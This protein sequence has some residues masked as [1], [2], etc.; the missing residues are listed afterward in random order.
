MVIADVLKRWEL[1]KPR[2]ALLCTGTDEH[3]LKVQQAADFQDVPPKTLCDT[4]SEIFKDLA[5]K[6][7]ISNDHFIRTTDPEHREAV[8]YFWRRLQENGHI[9]E[10]KHAGWYCVSDE[11]YYPENMITK[12]VHPHTGKTFMASIET[13][14][15]VEWTEEKNYHFRLTAFKEKLLEFFRENPNWVTP[16]SRMREVV[17]WVEN[18]LEDL[19]VSRPAS[20]L[21]WGIPVPDDPSQTIYVW[22][23]ALVNYITYAG[24]PRWTPGK[25]NRGG[26]PADV[27]VIGKD[28]MRFHCIYWPALLMAL[29]LPLPKRILTH[30]HWLMDAKKMSKS[31]GN[32]VNPFFAIDRWG[33]DTMRYYLMY[34]GAMAN[35][36]S[37]SNEGVVESY[38][39]GLQSTTGNFL[40]RITKPNKWDVSEAV[41]EIYRNMLELDIK[42]PRAQAFARLTDAHQE[43]V[44]SLAESVGQDFDN[45][46]PKAALRKIMH[47]LGESNKYMTEAAPWNLSNNGERDYTRLVH[48]IYLCAESMRVAAILLQPFIPE[49][50]AEILDRL[51]VDSKKRTLEYA[52]RGRDGEY[53]T[54]KCKTNQSMTQQKTSENEIQRAHCDFDTKG[55]ARSAIR[56]ATASDRLSLEEEYEN[57]ISWRTSADKL[58]FIVCK[59]LSDGGHKVSAGVADAN[60]HMVGDINLFLTPWEDDEEQDDEARGSRQRLCV[61]EVDIM[62]AAPTDRGRGMGKAAVSTFLWFIKK[63]MGAILAEY[64]SSLEDGGVLEIKELLVRINASNEGSKALFK[65]LGFEQRGEVNYF[66]EIEL[67]LKDFQGERGVSEVQEYRE[68]P[69]DRSGLAA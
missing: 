14:N 51:G 16:P 23:D 48:C 2:R 31:V 39:K 36:S 25:E 32:V 66:G 7:N 50:A 63:N 42:S 33:V 4:N 15:A 26:W 58:T 1:L 8:E 18:N 37:Y 69:F 62:I 30:G 56:E 41:R 43:L 68:L 54:P 35:D 11:T 49:K 47:F 64:A 19:S 52:K 67:V 22:I 27:H 12:Q 61:G 20:R 6:A 3:G 13:G 60:E 46:A 21:Q 55:V 38:K 44:D 9:Y 34:N 28:I 10:T 65:G 45:G 5:R 29:D 53:G 17:N 24:Y 59:P 57:Q 40:N